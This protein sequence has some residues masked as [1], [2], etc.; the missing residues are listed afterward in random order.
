MFKY[1]ILLVLLISCEEK[2][3][4]TLKIDRAN[5]VKKEK[6][7]FKILEKKWEFYALDFDPVVQNEMNNWQDWQNFSKEL[8]FKP[9]FSLTAF[10]Q[11]TKDLT[12]K[13][14]SLSIILPNFINKQEI[15]SRFNV[16]HLQLKN[17]EMFLNLKKI[18]QKKVLNQIDAVNEELLVVEK[19]INELAL[20]SKI[21]KEAGEENIIRLKDTTRAANG[22]VKN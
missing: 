8:Y 19:M 21:I 11:K 7:F 15:S 12:Q 13:S 5:E 4:D 14:D 1:I 3:D 10:K 16:L 20:K 2:K 9:K 6:E 22:V 18:N 17:L